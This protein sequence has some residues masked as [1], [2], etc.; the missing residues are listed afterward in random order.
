M[1]TKKVAKK[2]VKDPYWDDFKEP[3]K[4]E[5]KKPVKKEIKKAVKKPT[6]KPV[7]KEVELL[8]IEKLN[9]LP[10]HEIFASGT[11]RDIPGGLYMSGGGEILRWIAKKGG[12]NDWAIY[13]H[14][15]SWT[16]ERI[17]ANGDKV[18]MR[19]NIMRCVPCTEEVFN[20]YRY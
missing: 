15:A 3:L 8:T 18:T 20:R 9:A 19:E 16:K 5:V 17:A 4:E 13:C 14:R 6:E 2:E 12:A 10:R 11:L 1:A 7:E